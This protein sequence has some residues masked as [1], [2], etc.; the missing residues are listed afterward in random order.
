MARKFAADRLVIASHNAGKVREMAELMAPLEVEVCA[1][2]ELGLAEPEETGGTFIANAELKARA[3]AAAADMPAFADDSGLVVAALDC[4]P[5]IYS[6]RWSGAGRDFAAAMARVE[7][8]LVS[9]GAAPEGADAHFTS[10]LSL[11]WPDGHCENFE[12]YVHGNLSFPPR[13]EN[14]F[15]Y[16]PIFVPTGHRITFGEMPAGEKYAL[17]HRTRAF[18]KL[19]AA[20][21]PRYD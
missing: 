2:G 17:S 1:A 8:E 21:F 4:L 16:D 14:G 5:G 13:G 6:A 11:C 15:G 9:A 20:C 18:E 10:A 3:A 19:V 7:A 12:G